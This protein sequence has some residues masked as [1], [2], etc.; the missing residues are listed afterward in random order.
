MIEFGIELREISS[1]RGKK[2]K[3]IEKPLSRRIRSHSAAV[4]PLNWF[5]PK[6]LKKVS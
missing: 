3:S 6:F 5:V 1:A 4:T 2:G